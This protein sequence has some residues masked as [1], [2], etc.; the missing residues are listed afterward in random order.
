VITT[1]VGVTTQVLETTF[2]LEL[3]TVN[4]YVVVEL[5]SGVAYEAP[6]TAEVVM[7]E[8]PTPIEPMTAVPPENVGNN[9][10]EEL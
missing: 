7:S 6:L 5:S 2:P 10:T 4:V 1:G 3:V 9:I 8:L